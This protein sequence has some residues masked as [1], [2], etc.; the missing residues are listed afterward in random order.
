MAL[1]FLLLLCFQLLALIQAQ[2]TIVVPQ[3]AVSIDDHY[4]SL[5]LTDIVA[6]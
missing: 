2:V 3:C 5:H 6:G 4:G 1:S